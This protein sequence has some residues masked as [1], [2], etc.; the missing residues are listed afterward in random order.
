[1]HLPTV[2]VRRALEE[3]TSTMNT[4]EE[5]HLAEEAGG[6]TRSKDSSDDTHQLNNTSQKRKHKKHK[7]KKK[8][9]KKKHKKHKTKSSSQIT[10]EDEYLQ[11]ELLK[12]KRRLRQQTLIQGQAQ[13]A[14]VYAKHG[15]AFSDLKVASNARWQWSLRRKEGT[16]KDFLYDL[17]TEKLQF[18][19]RKLHNKR[20]LI[21]ASNQVQLL[22]DRQKATIVAFLREKH[23]DY[24]REAREQQLHTMT[25]SDLPWNELMPLSK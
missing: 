6:G 19:K 3:A 8:P 21:T 23:Y 16:L 1:M 2:I 9:K 14:R 11:E 15:V 13:R 22:L 5:N 10:M 18:T 24:A 12:Q 7:A 4:H 20:W 17:S 25:A